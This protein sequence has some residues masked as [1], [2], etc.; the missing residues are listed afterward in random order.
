MSSIT[1]YFSILSRCYEPATDINFNDVANF[2]F[3]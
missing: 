2:T 3:M 1:R